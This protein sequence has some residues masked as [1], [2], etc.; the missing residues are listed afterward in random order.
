MG[1][2]IVCTTICHNTSDN[3]ADLLSIIG[4]PTNVLKQLNGSGY[5]QTMQAHLNTNAVVGESYP[6]ESEV[7]AVNVALD[8][9]VFLE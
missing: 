9:G 8:T 3:P 5:C 6:T 4:T 2:L 1:I 7:N